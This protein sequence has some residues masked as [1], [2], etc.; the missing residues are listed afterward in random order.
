MENTILP[1]LQQT[2]V[3]LYVAGH[4]HNQ[5]II[6]RDG[7]PLHIITGTGGAKLHAIKQGA[8]DLVFSRVTL[9]FLKLN[10]DSNILKLGFYD[11]KGTAEARYG[12]DRSCT[13]GT[14]KCLKVM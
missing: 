10:V 12:I 2:H 5:Q 14:V 13:S 4:D 6:A 1:A 11:D 3:N 9:G 8:T 7:E